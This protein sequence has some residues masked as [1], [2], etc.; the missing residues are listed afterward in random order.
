MAKFA[1]IDNNNCVTNTIVADSLEIAQ[2][3]GNAVEFN[4]FNN[5]LVGDI[6]DAK[7]NAF[8]TPTE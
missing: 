6:Y 2:M 3:F 8:T 1:L 5:A 4:N 7:T